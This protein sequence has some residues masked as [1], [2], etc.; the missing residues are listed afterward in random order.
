[1]KNTEDI[2]SILNHEHNKI[3]HELWKY[4]IDHRDWNYG[5]DIYDNGSDEADIE[6]EKG[7]IEACMRS[8]EKYVLTP[9][10]AKQVLS[11]ELL[12]SLRIMHSTS[13]N[14]RA[15]H[16]LN[17]DDYY[18]TR[19]SIS[20]SDYSD[21]LQPLSLSNLAEVTEIYQNHDD[22]HRLVVAES[23]NVSAIV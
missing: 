16:R 21:D 19:C 1:M 18:T 10:N 8:F 20:R 6:S 15:Q 4:Y 11:V 5:R 7:Y 9:E 3:N 23:Y 13:L 22:T 17:P 14:W 12:D 2:I